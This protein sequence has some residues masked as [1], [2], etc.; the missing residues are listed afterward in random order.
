MSD[1]Q[2]EQLAKKIAS[3]LTENEPRYIQREGWKTRYVT[4]PYI[5]VRIKE[6]P[7]YHAEYDR[8]TGTKLYDGLPPLKKSTVGSSGFDCY[9]AVKEPVCLKTMGARTIIP[10]GLSISLPSNYELQVRPRSGLANKYGL[11]VLNTPGTI[12]S[13][14]RGEI[15]VIMV[16]LSPNK[17]W[18]ER[19][20]R[21]AQFVINGPLPEVNFVLTDDL[22]ET[23]R[24][25]GGFGHTG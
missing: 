13:D 8:S 14:Y 2:Y 11:T 1:H 5:D 24:G 7:H 21:I 4:I 22:E 12:D 9:A 19:G 20:M 10:T 16:N 3:D 17:F 23:E 6:L 25:Q 18:V 15:G